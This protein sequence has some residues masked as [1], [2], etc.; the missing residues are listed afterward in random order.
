MNNSTDT[1]MTSRRKFLQASMTAAGG[2]SLG[3]MLPSCASFRSNSVDQQGK[4]AADAWLEI[5]PDNRIIFTL[6]RVEMGQGTYT[7]L[8]TLLAEELK[9]SPDKIEI[10]FA[11]ADQVYRNPLYGLQITGGSTSLS[12]SWQQ[13]RASGAAAKE[14]LLATASDVLQVPVS[15]LAA[16]EGYVEHI[17]SDKRLSFGELAKLASQQPV[18]SDPKLTPPS[19]YKF[20]GKQNK[21]LDSDIKVTGK[22]SY[23]IDVEQKGMRYAVVSRSPYF[24]ATLKQHN[25]AEIAHLPGVETVVEIHNGVAVVAESYWRARKA[26]TQLKVEWERNQD[27][28]VNNKE[29]FDYYHKVANEDSGSSVRSEG[30]VD[31]SFEK[32]AKVIEYEFQAPFLAHATMEPMNC[33]AHVQENK[34]DIWTSTQGP[35]I[36]QVAVAKVTD[37]DLENVVIHNQFIGGGFGRR[38]SQDFVAEAAEISAK[39]GGVIKLV[40]SREDDIQHDLYRPATLH[41]LKAG[42]DQKGL[43]IAWDHQIIAPKIMDWYVWDASPAMFPW[44]PKFMYPMLGKTGL[45]TE[46]T[47]IT[48]SDTSPYEGAKNIPYSIPSIEVRHT[49]ADAGVPVTFWRSVGHSHNAFVVESFIDELAHEAGQDSFQFRQSYLQSSPRLLNVLNEVAKLGQWGRTT[50]KGVFQGIAVHESFNTAVAQIVE[51]KIEHGEIVVTKVFCAV[52]CGLVV[53]PDIVKMQMEGGI[54]FG[55]TAALYGEITLEE[56]KVKQSNFHDYKMLRM[57]QCPEIKTMIISSTEAPTGVGEPG[58]PPVAPAIANALF[59]ATGKRYRQLPF[60]LT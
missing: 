24:G 9:T 57:N 52:D 55:I 34:V 53:N 18:P 14:M 47:P 59:K 50:E 33:T 3:V 36:A 44:A 38:L 37:V 8:T 27:A 12:S 1:L 2:L 39:A 21:R 29:I 56:G 31:D 60:K 40:W 30:D 51:L 41:K 49:K 46:G 58:L 54:I 6:D 28:P 45:L 48:P 22:A 42:L 19:H 4:W 25:G 7:G 26:V 20:I 32:A 16:N 10:V 35:D 43:P 15:Y 11:G 5:T 23:G 13:I 17:G